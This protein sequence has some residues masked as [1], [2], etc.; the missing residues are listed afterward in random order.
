MKKNGACVP[1]V[2]V[3]EREIHW[4]YY[5]Q[6]IPLALKSSTKGDYN[7]KD[8]FLVVLKIIL[9]KKE[10]KGKRKEESVATDSNPYHG[11]KLTNNK[12]GD[13]HQLLL[14]GGKEWLQKI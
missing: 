2:N 13:Q 7:I 4:T 1:A 5:N 12:E 9:N 10:R 8:K 3:N 14:R 11:T 6:F